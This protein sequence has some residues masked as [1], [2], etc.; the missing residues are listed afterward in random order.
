MRK[1]RILPALLA[2]ALVI[3]GCKAPSLPVPD[4]AN[5]VDMEQRGDLA[6]SGTVSGGEG[7]WIYRV[8][9]YT[10]TGEHFAA[11]DVDHVIT[12]QSYQMP[13]MSVSRSKGEKELPAAA[14][15]AAEQFNAYFEQVLE[16]EAAW[17]DEVAA[18]AD[19]DYGA[20]GNERGSV[21]QDR[22]FCYWDEATLDFWSN[23]RILCVTTTRYSFTGGAHPNTWKSGV[24]FDLRTGKTVTAADLTDNV[25]AL[26][27]AVTQE[28]VRQ[29]EERMKK[30]AD[31]A[32]D[33]VPPTYYD[34]YAETL[35]AWMDRTVIF[36]EQGMTVIF[37]FY[38]IAPH[39]A[40]EQ[41][42]LIP[43][44]LL[45]AYLS[46]CGAEALGLRK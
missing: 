19:E 45:K 34:D 24:T 44:R 30:P 41:C 40:G 31:P 14:A 28:L 10:V 11:D 42:F 17:F 25:A 22:R 29:A 21:W 33:Y 35:G 39:D 9:T 4:S 18:A 1:L 6:V 8:T 13:T 27:T 38:D 15:R 43:Y 37:G 46:D 23:D 3:T 12:R 2:L 32:T 5:H 16:D 36:G 7:R 26:E 20:V